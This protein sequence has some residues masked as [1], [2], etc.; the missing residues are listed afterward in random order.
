MQD[1]LAELEAAQEAAAAQEM[2]AQGEWKKLAEQ[3]ADKASELEKQLAQQQQQLANERRNRMAISEATRLGVAD[4]TD[5]NVIAAVS[6][7]DPGG[8][9][10]EA[11][12]RKALEALKESRPYL[13]Q[14]NRP[15]GLASFNP[16]GQSQQQA[17][18]T[19][20]QKRARLFGGSRQFFDPEAA[21][22]SG[23][24]VVWPKG[25]PD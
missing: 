11:E 1:K 16:S 13:F 7:I 25:K 17:G 3:N 22:R 2:E 15:G 8:E 19:D 21:A 9:D 6:G 14:A 4:P 24:G 20:E 5:A 18:E 12:I 23:G 10:A